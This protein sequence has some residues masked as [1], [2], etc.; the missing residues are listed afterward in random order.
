M[1]A[2]LQPVGTLLLVNQFAHQNLYIGHL[3]YCKQPL[4]IKAFSWASV[5]FKPSLNT[6]TQLCR[7]LVSHLNHLHT[8]KTALSLH[9][10]DTLISA[11]QTLLYLGPLTHCKTIST[12]RPLMH[13]HYFLYM[14]VQ[15]ITNVTNV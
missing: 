7:G 9:A 13:L 12:H 2:V 6:K 10:K 14:V 8:L 4:Y 15:Q 11:C 1:Y 3:S 5:S